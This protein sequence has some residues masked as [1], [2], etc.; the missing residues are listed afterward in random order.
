[1]MGEECRGDW[2]LC[3]GEASAEQHG[4]SRITGAG[5]AGKPLSAGSS[6]AC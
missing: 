1:M 6:G 2:Q 4:K 5:L 3:H